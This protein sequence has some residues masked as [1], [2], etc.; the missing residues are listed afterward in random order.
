MP[1]ENSEKT[2]QKT[3]PDEKE[4]EKYGIR[5]F[6]VDCFHYRQYRYTNLADAIAQAKRDGASQEREG[7]HSNRTNSA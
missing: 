5:H 3:L 4:L 1:P 7:Y 6:A 2:D